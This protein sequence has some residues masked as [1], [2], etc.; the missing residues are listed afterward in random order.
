VRPGT[1]DLRLYRGDS[2]AWRFVVWGNE[3]RTAPADL[4]GAIPHAQIRNTSG[5]TPVV[6]LPTT[7][8]LPNTIK[9]DFHA[10][11]WVTWTLGRRAYWDLQVTYS[12]GRVVTVVRGS[13]Y[14]D[15]DVTD[16]ALLVDS[17]A[18]DG[19]PIVVEYPFDTPGAR[20]TERRVS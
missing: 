13:V 6:T 9:V 5:G 2:Y 1:F 7:I 10:S 12:T 19:S 20:A 18:P 3:E 11:Q 14:V 15:V 16:S 8:E 4:T 17:S